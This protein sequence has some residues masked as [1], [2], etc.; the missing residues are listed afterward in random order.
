MAKRFD[1]IDG[2]QSYSNRIEHELKKDG[3]NYLYLLDVSNFSAINKVFGKIFSN[4]ILLE[5]ESML[6]INTNNKSKL[7]KVES[8]RF[9]IL[10]NEKSKE[11]I[12]EYCE[13]IISFF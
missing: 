8:D 11:S 9:V 3:Y 7:F 13:Q 6:E 5:I 2:A 1:F 12:K 4:K 10:S